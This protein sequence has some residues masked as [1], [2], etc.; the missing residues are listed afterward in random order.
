MLNL[1]S[2]VHFEEEVFAVLQH[3]FD[4]SSTDVADG[5][6]GVDADLADLRPQRFVN[7]PAGGWSLFDQLLVATLD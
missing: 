2:R 3:P 6:G 5:L 1:N 4:R 7:Y